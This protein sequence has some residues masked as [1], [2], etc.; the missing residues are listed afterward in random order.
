MFN[1]I[2]ICGRLTHVPELKQTNNGRA[3]VRFTLAV[4]SLYNQKTDFIPVVAWNQAAENLVNYQGKGSLILVDGQLQVRSIGD[5]GNRRVYFDVVASRIVYM[6]TRKI[7]DQK[8]VTTENINP[9]VP[10]NKTES[11][12]KHDLTNNM[13]TFSKPAVSFTPSSTTS[14]NEE[15]FK[16]EQNIQS[17]DR[18]TNYN[19]ISNDSNQPDQNST[20]SEEDDIFWD[21]E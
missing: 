21:E 9:T 16:N 19:A 11:G 13:K 8:K 2:T 20:K 5:E 4:N 10:N 1:R 15:T 3:Y 18:Q 7:R 14:P 12:V 6:E 17:N